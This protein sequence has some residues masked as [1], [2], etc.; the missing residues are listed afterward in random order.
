[1]SDSGPHCLLCGC[2][3]AT[4]EDRVKFEDLGGLLVIDTDPGDV[5]SDEWLS[6]AWIIGLCWFEGCC[7]ARR[8]WATDA[9]IGMARQVFETF[10]KENLHMEVR[11][12][13]SPS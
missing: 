8:R 13:D 5:W 9:S 11:V 6:L 10:L 1:M 4:F 12:C 3:F 2:L 7:E